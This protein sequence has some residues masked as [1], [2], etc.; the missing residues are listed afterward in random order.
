MI[1]KNRKHNTLNLKQLKMALLNAID[2]YEKNTAHKIKKSEVEHNS[3]QL[4]F[5]SMKIPIFMLKGSITKNTMNLDSE[6]EFR[7][8]KPWFWK[9]RFH[10][11]YY[12]VKFEKDAN[13]GFS[14]ME[15]ELVNG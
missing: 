10:K 13:N 7:L 12:G 9:W 8:D 3:V 2:F 15:E 6:V 5:L 4:S 11:Y 1:V 14:V